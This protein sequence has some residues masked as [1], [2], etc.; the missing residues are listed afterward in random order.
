MYLAGGLSVENIKTAILE[1]N[2]FAVDA[3]SS[4]EEVKG[5]K[6]HTK[7]KAFIFQVK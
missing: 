2:P 5:M 3:C 6:N 7:V 1:V 4:V